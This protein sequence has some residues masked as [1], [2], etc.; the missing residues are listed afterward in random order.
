MDSTLFATER[1]SSNLNHFNRDVLFWHRVVRRWPTLVARLLARDLDALAEWSA[2]HLRATVP[3]ELV[4]GLLWS[5]DPKHQ[6]GA[7]VAR[8]RNVSSALVPATRYVCFE[9]I[10]EK[11]DIYTGDWDDRAALRASAL[12]YCELPADEAP[13]ELVLEVR[14]EANTTTRRVANRRQLSSFLSAVARASCL[15]F[16]EVVFS[17]LDYCGQVAAV[18]RA[19]ILVGIHGQGLSNSIFLHPDALLV[20]LF[21]PSLGSV[22]AALGHQPLALSGGMRYLG[23]QLAEPSRESGEHCA[24]SGGL[25]WKLDPRCTSFVNVSKLSRRLDDARLLLPFRLPNGSVLAAIADET[26]SSTQ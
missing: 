1:H 7:G 15:T 14:G 16:R 5:H 11:V 2:S 17:A 9:A 23:L 6:S 20:E 13:A 8:K 4:D 10:G 3:R 19:R 18:A 24:H 21:A 26:E 22:A 25:A 12:H